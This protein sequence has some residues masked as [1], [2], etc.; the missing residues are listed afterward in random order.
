MKREFELGCNK[1]TVTTKELA[2]QLKTTKDVI[3]ANAR[4]CLPAKKIEHGKP[5]FWSK[6]E[7]TVILDYIKTHSS[8]SRSVEFNSTVS[9]ATTELSPAL[10]IRKAML[11]MQAAYEDE[12]AILKARSEE[13]KQKRI[14]AESSL[15][16]IA[17]GRGCFSMN[18]AAKALKLSYGNITLYKK[19]RTAG[20]LNSDNSPAQEQ[21]NS[22]NFK[23]VVKFVS[24]KVGNKPVTLVTSKGLVYLSKRLNTS[25]DKSVKPDI[26]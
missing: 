24:D 26:E 21:A 7:V 5:T 16:R 2:E 22:G 23:V 8:N 6:A 13:E 1:E 19:L 14:A 12:L 17:D 10:R 4:K 3:L 9:N 20:I 25:I 15:N 18:Q 11:E